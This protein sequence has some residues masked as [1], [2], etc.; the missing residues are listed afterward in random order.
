MGTVQGWLPVN[1]GIGILSSGVYRHLLALTNIS[2]I[3]LQ[4]MVETVLATPHNIRGG[5]GGG[6]W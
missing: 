4:I 2:L 3:S 5:E 1:T 6:C